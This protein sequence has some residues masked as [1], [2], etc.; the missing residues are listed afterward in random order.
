ML[1]KKIFQSKNIDKKVEVLQT[2]DEIGELSS[3]EEYVE[4]SSRR[5]SS[6]G[7]CKYEIKPSITEDFTPTKNLVALDQGRHVIDQV[8]NISSNI[9]KDEHDGNSGELIRIENL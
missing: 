9:N 2:F 7:N 8:G 3:D 1:K 4:Q 6:H 5:N